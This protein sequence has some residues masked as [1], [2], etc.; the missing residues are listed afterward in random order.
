MFGFYMINI[1]LFYRLFPNFAIF[2]VYRIFPNF[3]LAVLQVNFFYF[4]CLLI[5]LFYDLLPLMLYSQCII[6]SW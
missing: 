6:F 2:S 5:A 3:S 4:C 1:I